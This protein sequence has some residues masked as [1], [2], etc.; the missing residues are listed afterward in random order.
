MK[1][2]INVTVLNELKEYAQLYFETIV[3]SNT[4]NGACKLRPGKYSAAELSEPEKALCGRYKLPEDEIFD[5]TVNISAGAFKC[6]FRYRDIFVFLR[7]WEAQMKAG[8][9][10]AVFEIGAVEE[11]TAKVLIN[12]KTEL[13]AYKTKGTKMQRI[14]GNWWM[15][16][17][18][19]KWGEV[20]LYYD[21]NGV[22]FVPGLQI[23]CDRVNRDF[24]S[25]KERCAKLDDAKIAE[26]LIAYIATE[27]ESTYL[28]YFAEVARLAR[29]DTSSDEATKIAEEAREKKRQRQQERELQAAEESEQRRIRQEEI[30]KQNE[31]AER[32]AAESL[33]KTKG[34]FVSGNMISCND[35]ERM[36]ESI[37]YSINIRTL[38]TLRKRVTWVEV[39]SEGTPTVYGTKTR[40]G[41]DGVFESIREV[42]TLIKEHIEEQ[43]T[44]PSETPQISIETAKVENE[45]SE[46]AN[47]PIRHI[48]AI[49][50]TCRTWDAET[51][52]YT[53]EYKYYLTT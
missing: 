38:G 10:K 39:D 5:E 22:V 49:M 13:G 29:I 7:N 8:R 25:V 12:E 9:A 15:P 3:E 32:Q 36:A 35:F 11:K 51:R 17:K 23:Y 27:T 26:M 2:Q 21:L 48:S 20:S 30:R 33:S 43:A 45:S 37:G 14:T 19:P 18:L 41:L 4:E 16:R 1:D 42:Y 47:E 53:D 34:D 46:E 31:E 44:T 6:A 50:E 52:D 28:R 24:D 40:R